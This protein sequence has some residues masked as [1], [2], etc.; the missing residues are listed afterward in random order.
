MV[1]VWW[2]VAFAAAFCSLVGFVSGYLT[3]M[4]NVQDAIESTVK[5]AFAHQRANL[6]R[7]LK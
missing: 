6:E 7:L 3:C 2:V 1:S 5:A 4:V